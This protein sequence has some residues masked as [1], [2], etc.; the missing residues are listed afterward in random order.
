MVVSE[1]SKPFALEVP[2]Y[3]PSGVLAATV[4]TSDDTLWILDGGEA[5]LSGWA[6]LVRVDLASLE[7]RV[8]WEGPRSGKFA[9]YWLSADSDGQVLLTSSGEQKAHIT[10]RLESGPHITD[11]VVHTALWEGAEALVIAPVAVAD[12]YVY[13]TTNG[14]GRITPVRVPEL[15]RMPAGYIKLESCM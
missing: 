12:G 13:A 15:K 10:V 6:R 8:I 14:V 11:V 2:G 9:R 1:D 4:G 3:K 5:K 7:Y